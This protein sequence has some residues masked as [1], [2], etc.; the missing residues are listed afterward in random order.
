MRKRSPA[1]K[2]KKS[3]QVVTRGKPVFACDL[4][5]RKLPHTHNEES[6]PTAHGLFNGGIFIKPRAILL[7]K[8]LRQTFFP[9][10][11]GPILTYKKYKP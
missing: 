6:K 8:L 10:E 1:P 3:L 7:E 2:T 9:Q 5:I 11:T 4:C